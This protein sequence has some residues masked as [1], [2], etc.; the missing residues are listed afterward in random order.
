[1][2]SASGAA[3]PAG[4]AAPFSALVLA[5]G[6][7]T[8]MGRDKALLEVDGIPLW[9]R[10]RD[11]LHAAGAAEIFLSAR[12]EFEWAHAVTAFSAVLYDA[13]PDCGPLMGIAAGLERASFPWLGVVAVDLP[14]L[15]PSWFRELRSQAAP[16]VGVV[17]RNGDHFEPLA[18]VYPVEI[19]W[20]VWEALARNEFALQPLLARAVREGLLRVR[21][22]RPD[23]AKQF[24]N[25][26]QPDGSGAAPHA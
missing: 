22:L 8:R 10:Q 2:S 1:M 9:R 7:S 15:T 5:G 20:L 19:K 23:E 25:W 26:N 16:G 13:T 17:G 14:A 3:E 4:G 24:L 11:L 6:R 21:D 18:A 12:P